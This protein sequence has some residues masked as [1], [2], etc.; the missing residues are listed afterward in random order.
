MVFASNNH[1]HEV[2]AALLQHSCVVSLLRSYASS[3]SVVCADEGIASGT[4][5]CA[6][7]GIARGTEVCVA[8]ADEGVARSIVVCG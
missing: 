7:E 6:D 4:V 2:V 8:C 5:V 3:G 1:G